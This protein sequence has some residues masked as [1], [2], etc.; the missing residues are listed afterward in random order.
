MLVLPTCPTRFTASPSRRVSTSPSWL[1]VS[2]LPCPFTF[3]NTN[4]IPGG[5]ST[6]ETA[7]EHPSYPSS[8]RR[9]VILGCRKKNGLACNTFQLAMGGIY[10]PCL[11]PVLIS[12]KHWSGEPDPTTSNPSQQ[13]F[14]SIEKLGSRISEDQRRADLR[15]GEGGRASRWDCS[16]SR[17]RLSLKKQNISTD[18]LHRYTPNRSCLFYR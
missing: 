12:R 1:L 9:V 3:V 10:K 13:L 7:N 8:S 11:A 6:P 2:C 5:H 4:W 17:M 18:Q 15:Q 14:I 16:S